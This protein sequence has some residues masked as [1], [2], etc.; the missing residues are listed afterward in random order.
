[1]TQEGKN[2]WLACMTLRLLIWGE[3]DWWLWKLWHR[4]ITLLQLS[5]TLPSFLILAERKPPLFNMN[6][7]SALYHIAQNDSP[8]LQSN[9]WWVENTPPKY[10]HSGFIFVLFV[11]FKIHFNLSTVFAEC[12]PMCGLSNWQTANGKNGHF[13]ELK[14]CTQSKQIQWNCWYN[15]SSQ[16]WILKPN[17]I[18]AQSE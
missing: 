2:A 17:P 9:E 3:A 14:K 4:N 15:T 5:L 16:L 12:R 13:I 8:T 10:Y 11:I 18:C 1:M 6:A 7:M